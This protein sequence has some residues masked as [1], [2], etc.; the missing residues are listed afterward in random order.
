MVKF[1]G[2]ALVASLLFL[3]SGAAHA[4][5][6][7]DSPLLPPTGPHA[8][9][10]SPADVHAT[11]NGPGLVIELENIIHFGFDNIQHI[12]S[13][14]N[15]TL[16]SFDS[17]VHGLASINGGPQF[18]I[19]L[20]GPVQVMVFNYSPGDLGNFQTEM[21]SLDLS[22]GGVTIRES[23]TLPS[24]GQTG[25]AG[26]GGGLYRIDS[27]FDVFTELSVDGGQML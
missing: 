26:I 12:P 19:L 16:E 17:K 13:P 18:P 22:G 10:L 24:L 1:F 4:S 14:P 21:L 25:I 9:Y 3:N 6:V 20:T 27:F 5:L 23:P 7:T 8:K 15:D 11:Y 2:S